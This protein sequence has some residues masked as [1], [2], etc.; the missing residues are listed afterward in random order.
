VPIASAI[1]HAVAK[2]PTRRVVQLRSFDL[3]IAA[4]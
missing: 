1:A 2:R 3:A 4:S